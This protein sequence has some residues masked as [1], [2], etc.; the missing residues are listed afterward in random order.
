MFHN[1]KMIK[2]HH[3]ANS[4][5]E[6]SNASHTDGKA[7][8]KPNKHRTQWWETNTSCTT[9]QEQRMSHTQMAH[10]THLNI[11]AKAEYKEHTVLTCRTVPR[12]KKAS[13]TDGA[14]KLKVEYCKYHTQRRH[15]TTDALKHSNNQSPV[16]TVEGSVCTTEKSSCGMTYR[17]DGLH[18][19]SNNASQMDGEKNTALAA[20]KDHRRI[21]T[22][23][24][25]CRGHRRPSIH[26]GKHQL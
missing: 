19:N 3:F 9:I 4:T 12:H 14:A 7:N 22:Q 16:Y 21:K 15:K 8:L 13:Q 20:E 24:Q 25:T 5:A 18:C 10:N 26:N 23:K 1:N 6:K 2:I 17:S 11:A